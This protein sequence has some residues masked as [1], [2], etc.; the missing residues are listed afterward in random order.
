MAEM[1]DRLI[2]E[3][4]HLVRA[5]AGRIASRLPSGIDIE[6][7]IG[8]GMLGLLSAAG[9]F[10]ESRGIPFDKYAEIRIRGSI[11]DEL[12]ALDQTSRS[13]RTRTEEIRSQIFDL[14]NRLGRTP[15]SE[16]VSAALGISMASYQEMLLQSAPN[17]IVSLNQP[18]NTADG[19]EGSEFGSLIADPRAAA[20]D[21]QTMDTESTTLLLSAVSDLTPRQRHVIKLHYLEGM[22][23]REVSETLEITEGRTSQLHSAAMAV[24]QTLVNHDLT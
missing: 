10:D 2:K 4:V 23:F 17:V 9:Q 15:T 7:L 5:V 21:E 20:P 3:N 8:A 12:R 19:G 1:S 14:A 22:N 13:A 6:D 24:L 16:E 11:L 18:L